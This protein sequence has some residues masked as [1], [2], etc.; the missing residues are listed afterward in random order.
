M[1]RE[2]HLREIVAESYVN[3]MTNAQIADAIGYGVHPDTITDYK[4]HP[5]VQAIAERLTKERHLQIT[6]KIDASLLKRL[7]HVDKIDTETLLKIRKEIL[8]ERIE[9]NDTTKRASLVEELMDLADEDPELAQRLLD[10]NAAAA[11]ATE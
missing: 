10:A 6:S 11:D 4:R 7:D 1:D 8:P 2:P 9:V 3:G 5:K